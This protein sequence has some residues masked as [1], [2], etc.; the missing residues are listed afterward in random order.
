[1]KSLLLLVLA[2]SV[3]SPAV[4]ADPTTAG[5]GSAPAAAKAEK[6]KKEKKICKSI[7]SS[8]SRLGTNVCKTA[9][10]WAKDEGQHNGGQRTKS[11]SVTN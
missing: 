3:A 4:A 11:F 2:A 8:E 5:T 9:A 7:A 6:P 1:M 10:E